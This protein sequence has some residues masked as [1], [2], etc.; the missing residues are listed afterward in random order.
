MIRRPPRS[1]RFP[2]TTLFRSR[3]QL[4]VARS[5]AG[6]EVVYHLAALPS[7]ARSEEHTSELPS[8]PHLVCRILLEKTNGH[9]L[10]HARVRRVLRRRAVD[11]LATDAASRALEAVRA[12]RQFFVLRV[13]APAQIYTLSLHDALPI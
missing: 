9:D 8:R 13:R 4:Q 3:D 11:L 6:V 12:R 5:V 10:L 7:V 1:T 2:Y